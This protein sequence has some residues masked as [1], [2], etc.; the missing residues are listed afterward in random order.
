M[1]KTKTLRIL[2]TSGHLIVTLLS[3][4]FAVSPSQP[5]LAVLR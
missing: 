4:P 1:P 3:E 2:L 5:M